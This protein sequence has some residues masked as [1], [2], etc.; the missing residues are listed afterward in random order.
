MTKK[1]LIVI[2]TALTAIYAISVFCGGLSQINSDEQSEMFDYL[3]KAVSEYTTTL[4]EG[5]KS[6]AAENAFTLAI[7]LLAGL[8]LPLSVLCIPVIFANGYTAGFSVTAMLRLYGIKGLVFCIPNILS[9]A[10]VVPALIFYSAASVRNLRTFKGTKTFG[11]Y[12]VILLIFL[13]AVFCVD[14]VIR[15]ALSTIFMKSASK[16]SSPV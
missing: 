10:F 4:S 1:T 7:L 11:K 2:F 16:L 8:F 15:G 13:T 5:I 6:V 9:A 12:F 3:S 14:S